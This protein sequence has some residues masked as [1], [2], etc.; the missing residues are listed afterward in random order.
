MKRVLALQTMELSRET[1]D[2]GC[3]SN[4]CSFCSS[5]SLFCE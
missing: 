1:F 3:S 5:C 2:D 4:S